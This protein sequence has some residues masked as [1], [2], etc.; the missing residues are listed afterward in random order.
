MKTGEIYIL[1]EIGGQFINAKAIIEQLKKFD[2]EKVEEIKVFINSPGGSVFE[3]L[4]IY[5]QLAARKNVTTI[6]EGL[7]ASMASVIALAGSKVLM[8]PSSL[9]LVHNPWTIAIVDTEEIQKL[10]Q[11]MEKVRNSILKIYIDKTGM[12]EEKVKTLMNENRFM[13]A[14][15]ALKKGFIDGIV[16]PQDAQN[17]VR[18]FVALG[19]GIKDD[20]QN[21]EE[22]KM[23]KYYQQIFVMLGFAP[24]QFSTIKD[25]EVEAK[26]KTLRADLKLK[27]DADVFEILTAMKGA[28]SAKADK[29]AENT[30]PAAKADENTGLTNAVK[31]LTDK[32]DQLQNEIKTNKETSAKAKAEE[33]VNAA[34]KDFQI[35]PTQKDTYI[36]AAIKDFEKTKAELSKIPKGT[37]KPQKVKVGGDG[38]NAVDFEDKESV[39]TAIR[40]V[41]KEYKDQ[42]RTID[43]AAALQVV[44]KR[45]GL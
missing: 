9:M 44:R 20:N 11:D 21:T 32:V 31:N 3:G 10:G 22:N 15:E 42:G 40:A 45:S 30:N 33:I 43:P 37:V 13:D 39:Q 2:E 36:D 1:D 19:A 35:L 38:K 18:S 4:T 8:R 23:N 6:V 26:L 24:E 14:E 16:K 34:V 17:Y 41:I 5:N 28:Q 29:N 7:A 27:E 25:E 12:K